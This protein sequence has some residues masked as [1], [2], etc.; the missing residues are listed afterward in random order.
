MEVLSTNLQSIFKSD[1][2]IVYLPVSGLTGDNLFYK[3][4]NMPWYYG[5]TYLDSL[6]E[7]EPSRNYSNS[8]ALKIALI[9][10]FG[11]KEPVYVVKVL[12]GIAR[13]GTSLYFDD[14]ESKIETMR[15]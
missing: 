14:N 1:T 10:K 12:A 4:T 6:S 5:P 11:T 9:K 8:E 13:V 15:S 2:K 7:M 3:S